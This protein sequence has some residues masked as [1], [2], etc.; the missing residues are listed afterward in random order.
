MEPARRDP[1][2]DAPVRALTPSGKWGRAGAT[3]VEL[4]VGVTLAVP[5]VVAATAL[6]IHA[7]RTALRISSASD[8]E[9]ALDGA[10]HLLEAELAPLAAGDGLL[11]WSPGLLRYR[12]HR[13]AGSWCA[14]DSL[15]V[16][17]PDPGPWAAS[18]LPVA[19][20]DTLVIDAPDSTRP[21]GFRRTRHSLAGPPSPQ[22]CPGGGPGFRLPMAPGPVP[23]AVAFLLTEEIVELVG[24]VSG[25]QTWLGLRQIAA[26]AAVDPVAGPFAPGGV[27]FETVDSSGIA[28]VPAAHAAG[29]RIQLVPAD[30]TVPRRDY[31]IRFRG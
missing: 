28:G 7:Q 24:Y 18:R 22:A 25:G 12:A 2:H 23:S 9:A 1:G 15:G 14:G 29:V 8:A 30:T 21:G 27:R 16:V 17:V 26:G 20:R 4:V 5:V 6:A 10:A 13:A 11:A 3:L 19:G 31:L